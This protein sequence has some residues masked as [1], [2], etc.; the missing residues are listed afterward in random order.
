MIDTSSAPKEEIQ[1]TPKVETPS[2][3]GFGTAVMIGVVA[4]VAV[5]VFI[6]LKR[7]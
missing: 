2:D 5:G 6:Y 3:K 4:A 7:K 1:P